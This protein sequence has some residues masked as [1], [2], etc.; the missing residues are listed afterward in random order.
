[1]RTGLAL[2]L[3]VGGTLAA[4]QV[5]NLLGGGGEGPFYLRLERPAWAPP[6]SVF[7]PVWVV[8]Y[9]LMGVSAWLVWRERSRKKVGLPLGLFV[10]HLL[11]NA[12]WTW[13]FFRLRD[14]ALALGELVALWV[15]IVAVGV[16][17]WRVRRLAAALL[18]PYLLWVSYAAALN[19]A[20]WRMNPS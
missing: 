14:I 15:L 19:F 12:A 1:M 3:W 9:V 18:L 4:G 10:V 11:F 2:V 13:L 16:L 5:A 6:A 8:L 20:L 17:F 7:G